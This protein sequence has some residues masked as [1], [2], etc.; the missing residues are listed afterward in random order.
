MTPKKNTRLCFAD[1]ERSKFVSKHDQ[2][3]AHNTKKDF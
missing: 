1:F 3:K 2:K